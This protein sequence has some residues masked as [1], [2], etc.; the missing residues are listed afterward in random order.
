MKTK[1]HTKD[2]QGRIRRSAE[3]RRKVI[4]RYKAS[5]KTQSAFCRER[6]IPLTTL[7][8]WLG[9]SRLRKPRFAQME[10]ALGKA[11]P[12]EIELPSRLCIRLRDATVVGDLVKFVREVGAC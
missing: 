9:R 2:R 10:V 12:I 5:G 6:G 11:A 1:T 8:Y 7:Q 4:E 3:D